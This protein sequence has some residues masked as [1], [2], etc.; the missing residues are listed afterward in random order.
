MTNRAWRQWHALAG[1][2]KIAHRHVRQPTR[3]VGA[4]H[5][6]T[7]A[8]VTLASVGALTSNVPVVGD[9]REATDLVE[10]LVD[11]MPGFSAAYGGRLSGAA[12]IEG[13]AAVLREVETTRGHPVGIKIDNNG[14]VVF[15]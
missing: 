6:V 14:H 2:L 9:D 3:P 12:A 1:S 10:A 5:L 13:M 8:H 7:A 11:E 15:E 4:L